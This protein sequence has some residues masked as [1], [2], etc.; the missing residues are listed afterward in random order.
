MPASRN[1]LSK[2]YPPLPLIGLLLTMNAAPAATYP[3]YELFDDLL[4]QNVRGGFVDYDGLDADPRFPAFIEQIGIAHPALLNS[5]REQLAFYI[6]SYNAL[7]LKGILDGLSPGS[8]LSRNKFFKR[9]KFLLL[10]E[11]ISLYTLEHDRI[12]PMGDPRIHFAIVCASLSCPRL[13]SR[14]YLSGDIDNQLHEAAKLFIN[15]PTRNRF[16][17]ERRIA[18]ISMIFEWYEEDF[19]N[20]GGSVQQYLARFVNDARV[21]DALRLDEFELRYETYDW[22]LNGYFS[23]KDK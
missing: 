3:D 14:A 23:G 16:D 17:L 1:Y 21:Q 18:F 5:K 7:A 13:S 20:A 9:A 2:F 11:E 6:N 8:R 19:V 10:G 4:L 22:S 15:D 12:I